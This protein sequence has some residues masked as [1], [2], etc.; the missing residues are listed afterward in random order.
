MVMTLAN[1]EGPEG[2]AS[3][4]VNQR[5]IGDQLAMRAARMTPQPPPP[6]QNIVQRQ[7]LCDVAGCYRP[8]ESDAA[9]FTM[10]QDMF[11]YND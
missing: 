8:C 4:L 1:Q 9:H 5:R 11:G 3:R 6:R 7:T 2:G 10:M